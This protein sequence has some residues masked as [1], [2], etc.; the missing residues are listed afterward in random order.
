[1][2]S[3]KRCTVVASVLLSARL[4]TGGVEKP[5]L[6][7]T[8]GRELR[9]PAE[10]A[11]EPLGLIAVR[12]RVWV[13]GLPV[14]TSTAVFEGDTVKTDQGAAAVVRL[15]SGMTVALDEKGEVELGGE[16]AGRDV[17]LRQ[18]VVTVS[19]PGEPMGRVH[20]LGTTVLVRGEAGR[21]GVCRIAA[22]GNRAEV[23]ADQGEMEIQEGGAWVGRSVPRRSGIGRLTD[24]P[25]IRLATGKVARLEAPTAVAAASRRGAGASTA[26]LTLPT[27]GHLR[28]P[29]QSLP[30]AA[31]GAPQAVRSAGTVTGA[32]PSETVQ[33]QGQGAAHPLALRDSV[34]WQ[35]VVQTQQTGRVRIT[36]LDGSFL[37]VGARSVMRI[38]E[39]NPQTQQTQVELT[40]GRVRSQV[41]KLTKPG[42]SFQMRTQTAV[43][44]VVGTIFVVEASQNSTHV[45]CIEGQV[46][47][48]NINPAIV[49][50]VQLGPGQSTVVASG[51]APTTA[52]ATNATELQ[53]SLG[54]TEVQPGAATATGA[55]TPPGPSGAGGAAGGASGAGTTITVGTAAA[56]AAGGVSAVA[57]VTALAKADDAVSALDQATTALQS[58]TATTNAATTTTIIIQSQQPTLSPSTPCG[59]GP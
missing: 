41:V 12:G 40:L 38:V 17:T 25:R 26:A 23:L 55:Q 16:G 53:T 57:G 56:A 2:P 6:R 45:I 24:P 18:G 39:H 54:E 1:M 20:V 46:T 59:C 3:Q 44:G 5:A 28:P 36:L 52:A 35:D 43:I 29:T 33:R 31:G 32:I 47:V 49:G 21:S 42:A 4:L 10:R 37:N 27:A 48:Q 9:P 22:F 30:T 13:D 34:N 19:N 15:R 11:T 58:A 50:Q 7:C 14:P 51:A 8:E